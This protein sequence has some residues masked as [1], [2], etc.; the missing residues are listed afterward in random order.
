M[1]EMQAQTGAN[2]I[3]NGIEC[4]YFMEMDLLRRFPMY[5]CLGFRQSLKH[6]DALF[7][8]VSRQ[9]GRFDHALDFKKSPVW[10][11]MMVPEGLVVM[12][13]VM[14]VSVNGNL[15]SVHSIRGMLAGLNGNMKIAQGG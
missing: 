9:G 15:G 3:R 2:D 4:A 8:Y 5:A 6:G 14:L 7:L 1:K 13:G 12:M 10:R 11:V